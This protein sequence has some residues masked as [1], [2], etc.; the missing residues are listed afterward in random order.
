MAFYKKQQQKVNG[1]WYPRSVLVGDP[2]TTDQLALRLAAESTL[3][4]I[5]VLAVLKGLSGIMGEYMAQGRSV[6]LNGIGSFSLNASAVGN[7]VDTPEEVSANQINGVKVHFVPATTYRRDGCPPD[8]S[9]R[10]VRTLTD[11]D[12][13]WID[14]DSLVK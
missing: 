1:K 9:R 6:M 8:K 3:S 4:P 5:D 10:A 2:I 13:E 14:I 12:I 7:G 11:V